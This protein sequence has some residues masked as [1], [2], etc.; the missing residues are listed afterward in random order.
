[1]YVIFSL[2]GSLNS[3]GYIK[4]KVID[5]TMSTFLISN[6]PSN[7]YLEKQMPAKNNN[8]YF[9]ET[10]YIFEKKFKGDL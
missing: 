7:K 6:V 1:M 5:T 3:F 9:I 4:S 10:L 2:N 8:L